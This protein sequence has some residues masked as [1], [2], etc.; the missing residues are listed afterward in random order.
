MTDDANALVFNFQFLAS[1]VRKNIIF[2]ITAGKLES[3]YLRV[4]APEGD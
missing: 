2:F 3:L 4:S 1:Q